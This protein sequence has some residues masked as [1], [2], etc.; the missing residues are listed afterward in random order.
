[1]ADIQN[2]IKTFKEQTT[3]SAEIINDLQD[4]VASLESE[5][6][7]L[8]GADGQVFDR[9]VLEG[10][11]QRLHKGGFVHKNASDAADEVM[12]DPSKVLGYFEKFA[13]LMDTRDGFA[14]VDDTPVEAKRTPESG[15]EAAYKEL[16]NRL[17]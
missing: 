11:F 4:K 10:I 14:E 13:S 3:I 7:T 15:A 12:D 1:M 9:S 2:L 16:I 8:V 17:R 5:R 6:E